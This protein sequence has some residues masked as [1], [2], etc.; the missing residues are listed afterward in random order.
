ML[1][2]TAQV[3][4]KSETGRG[5]GDTSPLLAIEV[6][7]PELLPLAALLSDEIRT[8]FSGNDNLPTPQSCRRTPR[9]ISSFTSNYNSADLEGEVYVAVTGRTKVQK[10]CSNSEM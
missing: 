3:V 7:S 1:A 4:E 10:N 6:T 8:V 9:R 2:N 5:N